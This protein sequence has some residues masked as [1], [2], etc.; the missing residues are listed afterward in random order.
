MLSC[1]NAATLGVHRPEA[2]LCLGAV[3]FTGQA[4]PDDGFD[5]ILWDAATAR[6]TSSRVC[7]AHGHCS[8]AAALRYQATASAS[9]CWTPRP[10][11]YI[12]PRLYCASASPWSAALR[13]SR[14][15]L[16]RASCWTPR[17]SA[18]IN[19]SLSCASAAPWSIALRY[20]GNGFGVIL[21]GRRDRWRTLSTSL[22]CDGGITLVGS[23][24]EP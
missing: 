20:A 22:T 16:Q 10:L 24:A 21:A 14:R 18:Y 11:A 4:V 19:P 7:P 8:D 2:V 23:F 1:G 3:L 15:R 5:V 12:A 17:P 9:S 13:E 6:R